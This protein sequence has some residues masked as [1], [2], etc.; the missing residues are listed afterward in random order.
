MEKYNRLTIIKEV[1]PKIYNRRTKKRFECKC[2]CNNLIIV[3]LEHLKNGHTK[4]CGC[5]RIEKSSEIKHGHSNRTQTY[6][7]WAGMKQ[8]CFYIK[9]KYYFNY[10]GRGI[11]VCERWMNFSNFLEDMGERPKGTTLDRINPNGNYEPSNCRWATIEE[12][13]KNRRI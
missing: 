2:D 3:F 5:L 12:Q 6:N 1:E 7:S 4:S 9:H 10:G 13:I 11:T 8:R